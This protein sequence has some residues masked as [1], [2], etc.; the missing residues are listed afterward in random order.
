[1]PSSS[2]VPVAAMSLPCPDLNTI[3][4]VEIGTLSPCHPLKPVAT[5]QGNDMLTWNCQHQAPQLR[6]VS[7]A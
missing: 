4:T 7:A 5:E 3:F 2:H 1:M 6:T